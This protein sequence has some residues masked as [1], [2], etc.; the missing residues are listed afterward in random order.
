[1][2]NLLNTARWVL[3]IIG[4]VIFGSIQGAGGIDAAG[5][6]LVKA[7]AIFAFSGVL[8]VILD[9]CYHTFQGKGQACLFCGEIRQMSSFRI[10][11]SCK[12]C[13]K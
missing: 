8:F 2:K 11:S 1:M 4:T 13:G 12:K 3:G 7:L 5:G 9:V 6:W 10:Y